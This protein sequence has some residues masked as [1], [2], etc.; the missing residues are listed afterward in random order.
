MAGEII[1]PWVKAS[2]GTSMPFKW[3]IGN[4]C[5][6]V[7]NPELES[8]DLADLLPHVLEVRKKVISVCAEHIHLGPSLSQVLGRTLATPLQALWDTLIADHARVQTQADFDLRLRAF[9][10]ANAT[11]EDRHEL[12]LQLRRPSKPHNLSVQAF[13]Y[14]LVELNGYVSWLPGDELPLTPVSIKQAFYDGMPPTWRERFIQA[15]HS[16]PLVNQ[17][18]LSRYFRMQEKLAVAKANDNMA[19]QRA[20]SRKNGTGGSK[21]T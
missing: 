19:K 6:E 1:F 11:S 12:V 5:Y 15:G 14:R 17:A 18:A 10:A 3:T 8:F 20:E 7:H 2:T 9:I 21:K 16:Q 13:Y 4:A